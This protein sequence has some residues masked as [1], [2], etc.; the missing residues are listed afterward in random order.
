[1][2]LPKPHKIKRNQRIYQNNRSRRITG[3]QVLLML[4]AVVALLLVG[5]GLYPPLARWLAGWEQEEAPPISQAGPSAEVPEEPSLPAQE[6]PQ[7]TPA[8]PARQG[9]AMPASL[10]TDEAG[11][12]I[13]LQQAA[14]AGA[15]VVLIPLK[16]QSG[17]IYYQSAVSQAQPAVVDQAVDLAAL[18]E[19]VRGYGLEPVGMLEGFR[20]PLAAVSYK[21]MAVLYQGGAYTWMDNDPALGGKAWLNP[22]S[23]PAQ[24]YLLALA[25]EVLDAG[26]A[27]VAMGSVQFP[28][29]YSLELADYG[30]TGGQTPTQALQG[31]CSRL[32][33]LAQQAG[34]QAA[35]V[36]PAQAAEQPELYGEGPFGYLPWVIWQVQPQAG[37]EEAAQLVQAVQPKPG[38]LWLWLGEGEPLQEWLAV[39]GVDGVVS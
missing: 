39:P 2:G 22:Y 3:G 32:Q 23:Q 38:Q 15:Q 26:F 36:L 30:D 31:F 24:D 17:E 4:A 6:Q 12:E 18:G 14:Q 35:L 1:M 5:W 27:G 33:Q 19:R 10:L 16:S 8:S 11:M 25:Q 9:A 37:P 29:G 20:D 34:G 21:E 28:Q 13:W 7:E